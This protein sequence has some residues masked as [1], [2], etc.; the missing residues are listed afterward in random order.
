MHMNEYILKYI[1]S[2]R[3]SG[4]FFLSSSLTQRDF[5]EASTCF[6]SQ[7]VFTNILVWKGWTQD[8]FQKVEFDRPGERSPE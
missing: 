7:C 5:S 2:R 6:F 1:I 8:S 4:E 3:K